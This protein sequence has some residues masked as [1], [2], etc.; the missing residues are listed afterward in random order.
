MKNM[1][2]QR[3]WMFIV[4]LCAAAWMQRSEAATAQLRVGT[5][6]AG[7]TVVCDGILR[8]AAPVTIDGLAPGPHLIRV[9]LAGYVPDSR[10]V[11]LAAGE[12]SA[13]EINLEQET[14]LVL[15]HST[16]AGADIAVDGAHRGKAPL[17]LTDLPRGNYRIKASSPGYQERE[18]ELRVEGRTPQ[19]LDVTLNSDSARLT[20]NSNP[21]GAAVVVNGLSH[22]VTPCVI[23]QVPSGESKIVLTMP[24]YASYQS[25]VTLRAGD[26]H[27]IDA[28]LNPLPASLS[29]VGV[30]AGAKVYVDEQLR[31]Q[32]PL[33]ME[34]I[35]PGTYSVRVEM[36]GYDPETR[37]IEL[38][39]RDSRVEEFNL[40]RNVGTLEVVTDQAGTSIMVNG[41]DKGMAPVQTD[42]TVDPLRIELPVGEYKVEFVKKGYFPV[43]K[44]VN[45]VKSGSV[46]LR[47]SMKRNFVADTVVRLKSNEVL[48]GVAGRKFPNG[49]VEIETRPGIFKTV[50]SDEIMSIESV[51]AENR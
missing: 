38:K 14:G 17:L 9:E 45:I 2:V 15:V 31:G 12:K 10:T 5:L 35:A 13:V 47:E 7:A 30:P 22:G 49:D 3:G 4:A 44:T 40:V 6:P 36:N 20:V 50:K 34:T 42:K 28:E 18:M 11:R 29:I 27:K 51:A 25:T 1:T 26:D 48:T 24:N 33:T 19:K 46:S 23:E 37:S 39:N 21:E 41:A 32:T 43:V 16:P 8:D